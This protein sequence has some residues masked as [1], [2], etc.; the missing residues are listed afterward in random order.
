[1]FKNTT[2]SHETLGWYIIIPMKNTQ[3]NRILNTGQGYGDL[4]YV[5]HLF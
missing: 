1:M 5:C 3:V 2:C 4:I